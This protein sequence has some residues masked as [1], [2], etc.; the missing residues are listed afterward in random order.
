MCMMDG[1]VHE[2]CMCASMRILYSSAQYCLPTTA[3]T[4]LRFTSLPC[5]ISTHHRSLHATNSLLAH[6]VHDFID[7]P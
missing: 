1:H 4:L 2:A 5:L 7:L 3:H 6:L